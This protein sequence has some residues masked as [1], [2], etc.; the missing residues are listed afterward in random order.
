MKLN[1]EEQ[2]ELLTK[3]VNHY[4]IEAQLLMC[5]EE[6]AELTQAISKVLRGKVDINNLQEEIADVE[7]CLEY[8]KMVYGVDKSVI[9]MWKDFKLDRLEKN[10]KEIK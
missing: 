1:K 7:I 4:G 2:K 5:V 8:V 6:M 9:E 3:A 10:L